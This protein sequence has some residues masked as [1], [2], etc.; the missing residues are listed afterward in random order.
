[1]HLF[2]LYTYGSLITFQ[3]VQ[4]CMNSAVEY[5]YFQIQL[6]SSLY[7]LLFW[8]S[9]ITK[10]KV[11]LGK[12]PILALSNN[13]HFLQFCLTYSRVHISSD[14]V[15]SKILKKPSIVQK[16][17]MPHMKAFGLFNKIK[18]KIQ[19][20]IQKKNSKKIQKKLH[21]SAKKRAQNKNRQKIAL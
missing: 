17:M 16:K 18:Q 19:K 4:D 5:T 2:L 12:F 10:L 11:F 15:F 7:F 14:E 1:M 6:H 9:T 20:K 21:F 3:K 8:F 13:L